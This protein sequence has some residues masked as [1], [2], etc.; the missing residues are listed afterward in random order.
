MAM[1][2]IGMADLVAVVSAL[3]AEHALEGC[4]VHSEDGLQLILCH[5]VRTC[6]QVARWVRAFSRAPIFA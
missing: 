2:Y 6:M 5:H 3:P 4:A 1:A